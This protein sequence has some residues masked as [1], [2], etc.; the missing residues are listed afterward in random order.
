[1]QTVAL[2]QSASPVQ[3]MLLQPELE[4]WTGTPVGA[5]PQAWWAA[6]SAPSSHRSGRHAPSAPQTNPAPQLEAEHGGPQ[7]EPIPSA[8]QPSATA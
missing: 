2:G 6:H 7:R 1:M 5:A 3:E 8:L 4:A